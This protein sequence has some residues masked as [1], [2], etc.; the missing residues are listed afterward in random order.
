MVLRRLQ[1][2]FWGCSGLL[3][4]GCWFSVN[5]RSAN[6]E[7]VTRN[8]ENVLF[9]NENSGLELRISGCLLRSLRSV[10]ISFARTRMKK[11]N[12]KTMLGREENS[13]RISF[14]TLA[15]RQSRCPSLARK[16]CRRS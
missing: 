14:L 13:E 16:S 2:V 1:V 8:I 6:Y 9:L 4:Q 5:A 12:I 10:S 3:L 15:E 11:P 7:A